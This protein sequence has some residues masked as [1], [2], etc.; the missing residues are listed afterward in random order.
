ML[1]VTD[2]LLSKKRPWKTFYMKMEYRHG[3]VHPHKGKA[4]G[5]TFA[6]T[7]DA[8]D[9]DSGQRQQTVLDCVWRGDRDADS[10]PWLPL[11]VWNLLCGSDA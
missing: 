3:S 10:N 7:G 11:R 6:L 1:A 8:I 2:V 4:Q 5:H 9:V